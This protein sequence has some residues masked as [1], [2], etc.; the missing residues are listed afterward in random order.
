MIHTVS[1]ADGRKHRNK[2]KQNKKKYIGGQSDRLRMALL[3]TRRQK[4]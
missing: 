2:T 1:N 3:I 4:K